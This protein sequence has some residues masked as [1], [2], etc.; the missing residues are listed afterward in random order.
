MAP[1]PDVP[2]GPDWD[3]LFT[4]EMCAL[5]ELSPAALLRYE[6][7]VFEFSTGDGRIA[8]QISIANLLRT[9]IR[10]Q[11][12]YIQAFVDPGFTLVLPACTL[13]GDELAT[14]R[15]ALKKILEQLG[16][17][18]TSSV[19]LVKLVNANHAPPNVQD[20]LVPSESLNMLRI[21][22][23]LLK[24]YGFNGDSGSG[25]AS[26]RKVFK[27]IVESFEGAAHFVH[28]AT[29]QSSEFVH[30]NINGAC[31]VETASSTTSVLSS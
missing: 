27:K 12:F 5:S 15:K 14:V 31:P 28:S 24:Q 9:R 11:V 21:L 4:P 23:I 1:L 6:L 3:T 17:I 10:P 20:L 30:F 22:Q 19:H 8:P 18:V 25:S 29:G 7:E 16:V 2:K 26:C 13:S